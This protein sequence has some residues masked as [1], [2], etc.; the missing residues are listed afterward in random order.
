M[1]VEQEF[2]TQVSQIEE[3]MTMQELCAHWL[4]ELESRVALGKLKPASLAAYRGYVHNHII[5]GLG[6]LTL[7]DVRR[8]GHVKEFAEAIA[9]NKASAKPGLGPKATREVVTAVKM[10]LESHQNQDGECLLDL[11]KWNTDFI[12][13]NVED[14][15]EPSQ[16]VASKEM[17]NAILRSQDGKARDLVLI[18]LT[19]STGLRIGE[20][21]AI[22]IGNS[23]GTCWN[24]GVIRVRESI[25]RG[26]PQAP[27]TPAA[28]R[29]VDLCLPVQGML[30]EFTRGRKVGEFMFATGT[31]NPLDPA[32]VA[33][34]ILT[35]VGIPGAH[36]LRRYRITYLEEQNCPR[37]LLAAW[38]G[39]ANNKSIT[40]RY[41]KSAEDLVY[42]RQWV[43]RLGTGLDI[44]A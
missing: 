5:P 14:P 7:E 19:A 34:Q 3:T 30:E 37:S 2:T 12:F 25:W 6:S 1:P 20:L 24:G 27:K 29:E 16:P 40:D 23:P 35:P 38:V 9:A 36:S 28:I 33:T 8:N 26:K 10:I 18:A 44:A 41:I 21:I 39:H 13:K 31:G 17:I 15:G 4:Q 43:E 32:Y 22:R 42:R 11:S